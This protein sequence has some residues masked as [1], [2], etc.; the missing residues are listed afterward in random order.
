[1]KKLPIKNINTS[2]SLKVVELSS[3]PL[4]LA[5]INKP[6]AKSLVQNN[7]SE[8]YSFILNQKNSHLN[9][10]LLIIGHKSD[11]I[12]I[13]TQ[14]EHLVSHTSAEILVKA[15]LF[16]QSQLDFHGLIK[17]PASGHQTKTNL[18]GHCLLLSKTTKAKFLPA[19][20]IITNDVE[21][22]HAATIGRLDEDQLFYLSCRGFTKE[23]ASKLLIEAFFKETFLNLSKVQQELV[24]AKIQ[25][26]LSHAY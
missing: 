7:Y 8:N 5:L 24:L 15:V 17:I 19:L 14:L 12:K 23:V 3:A 18:I 26:N 2:Y 16:D 20:E 1:M 9:L 6:F 25:L 11:Y 4:V 13:N 21:A 22:H 10:T